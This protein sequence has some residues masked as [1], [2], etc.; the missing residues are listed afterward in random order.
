MA[1]QLALTFQPQH[2]AVD[3]PLTHNIFFVKKLLS[4]SFLSFAENVP[5]QEL[6]KGL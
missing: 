3:L 2:L 6:C 4:S 5:L 1:A